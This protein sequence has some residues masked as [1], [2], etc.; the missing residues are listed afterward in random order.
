M[1][2]TAA[3]PC[4]GALKLVSWDEH[5]ARRLEQSAS[6]STFLALPK[7]A[8]PG[9]GRAADPLDADESSD[10][11]SDSDDIPTEL[12]SALEPAFELQSYS[13][14]STSATAGDLYRAIN[15]P[16]FALVRDD[17]DAVKPL[18]ARDVNVA[19]EGEPHLT[20]RARR[21]R[22]APLKLKR[23]SEAEAPA[24]KQPKARKDGRR[25][26]LRAK[27]PNAA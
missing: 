23:L 5:Q 27:A 16:T 14:S 25:R 9:L 21:P 8:Q 12:R 15:V 6:A 24:S 7:P 20:K 13:P 19:P 1:P 3:V 26:P 17:A 22:P 11:D 10:S 2:S 4:A 18:R